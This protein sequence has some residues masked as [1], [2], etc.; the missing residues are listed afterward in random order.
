MTKVMDS[1]VKGLGAMRITSVIF[2]VFLGSFRSSK[3]PWMEP[4]Y[5]Q[6]SASS[7]FA[8]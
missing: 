2:D 6:G 4:Q 3:L 5:R 8:T 7:I 1:G